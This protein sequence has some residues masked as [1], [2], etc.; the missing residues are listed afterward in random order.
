MLLMGAAVF[1]E[2]ISESLSPPPLGAA[3]AAGFVVGLAAALL[4]D[5]RLPSYPGATLLA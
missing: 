5:P 3:A 1:L 4:P 2:F